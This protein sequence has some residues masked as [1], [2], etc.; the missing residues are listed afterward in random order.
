MTNTEE[1]IKNTQLKSREMLNL[2][3]KF[4]VFSSETVGPA[5]IRQN[6]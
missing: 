6:K 3:S 4:C 2:T 1:I 5:K